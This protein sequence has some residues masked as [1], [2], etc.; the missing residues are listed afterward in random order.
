MAGLLILADRRVDLVESG[1]VE[2]GLLTNC[3]AGEFSGIRKGVENSEES[4][5]IISNSDLL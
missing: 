1:D 5:L 3:S 2:A 4:F